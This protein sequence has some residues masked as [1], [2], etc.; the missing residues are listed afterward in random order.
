MPGASD[1]SLPPGMDVVAFWQNR[2][3]LMEVMQGA[4][5]GR[6]I[7]A[8]RDKVSRLAGK[9]ETRDTANR[10]RIYADAVSLAGQ[11][12]KDRVMTLPADELRTI[13][14]TMLSYKIEFALD[15]K[16]SLLDHRVA[17]LTKRVDVKGLLEVTCPWPAEGAS[18][19]PLQPTLGTLDEMPMPAR[20]SRFK[21][22]FWSRT[23]A[24]LLMEANEASNHRIAAV[25]DDIKTTF[26]EIDALEL[27]M[28][29][30]KM[31]QEV[32]C[33]ANAIRALV[34][35][36][37]DPVY[38]EYISHVRQRKGKTDKSIVTSTANAV[39]HNK[40]LETAME[41]M[42]KGRTAIIEWGERM[43][44]HDKGLT[45]LKHDENGLK[46]LLGMIK[47]LCKAKST[48]GAV[49]FNEISGNIQKV[50]KHMWGHIRGE[51]DKGDRQVTPE[52]LGVL[53]Q[54]SS[55]ATIAW[56]MDDSMATMQDSVAKLLSQ[57]S[58][59]SNVQRLGSLVADGWAVDLDDCNF[60]DKVAAMSVAITS[61]SHIELPD[62]LIEKL[63]KTSDDLASTLASGFG[64][65]SDELMT[66]GLD[67]F[68]LLVKVC[69]GGL[70]KPSARSVGLTILR[71][72]VHVRSR[73]IAAEEAK[74]KADN[75]LES[76]RDSMHDLSVAIAQARK[77]LQQRDT[78]GSDGTIAEVTDE[79]IAKADQFSAEFLESYWQ[80]NK[81]QLEATMEECAKLVEGI[82]TNPP[83]HA[84]VTGSST[85]DWEKLQEVAKDT[86]G[87]LNTKDFE[88]ALQAMNDAKTKCEMALDMFADKTEGDSNFMKHTTGEYVRW[89]VLLRTALLM[90]HLTG[91][92]D[93]GVARARIQADVKV[94]RKD[95]GL[96]EKSVLPEALFRKS[97]DILSCRL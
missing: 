72:C 43:L 75:N 3:P 63:A 66:T 32:L 57:Q 28:E 76:R 85:K 47:D 48:N 29:A 2:L 83:W 27:D 38:D 15:V 12:R 69:P 18:F 49:L 25:C 35:R 1:G 65:A 20:L 92:L 59:E 31:L 26:G 34:L 52:L 91:G 97:W 42:T 11:L 71:A 23:M 61:V 56:S 86:I 68:E 80:D 8:L 53:E 73:T 10:L 58:S 60:N 13:V 21:T 62:D 22:Q 33:C 46:Q 70:Q 4:P 44:A 77:A 95:L 90:W 16:V 55:E 36:S 7:K 74:S 14:Q 89:Q 96:K 87:K 84:T 19:D 78:L 45:G 51:I 79:C 93:H 81:K 64:D 94:I 54:I 6:T 24:P 39:A 67:L 41:D 88:K 40:F 82:D 50:V 37:V 30:A 9:A 17:E 5:K